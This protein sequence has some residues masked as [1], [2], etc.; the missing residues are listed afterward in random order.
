M[1]QPTTAGFNHG[2]GEIVTALLAEGM[3][4]TELVEHQ[5]GRGTRSATRW[6]SVTTGSGDS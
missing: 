1:D 5:S 2:L 6:C 3:E 4:L